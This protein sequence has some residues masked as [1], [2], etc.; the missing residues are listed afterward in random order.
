MCCQRQTLPAIAC[1]LGLQET[2]V[3]LLLALSFPITCRHWK[4]AHSEGRA[5]CVAFGTGTGKTHTVKG[6]LNV[7]HL[8]HF[9]RHYESTAAALTAEAKA[10]ASLDTMHGASNHR[11]GFSPPL[12]K[13]PTV[14]L[15]LRS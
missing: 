7:W 6:V 15:T 13:I 3:G 9:V 11:L 5:Q 14:N 2:C 12:P 8:T 1:I 10:G 4:D